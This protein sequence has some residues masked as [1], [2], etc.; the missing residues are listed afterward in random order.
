M[1]QKKLED[2]LINF[3]DPRDNKLRTEQEIKKDFLYF[4]VVK[5]I[6]LFETKKRIP[7]PF[8]SFFTVPKFEPKTENE[9][10][11]VIINSGLTKDL[12]CARQIFD[13]LQNESVTYAPYH[14]F[15]IGKIKNSSEE[16]RYEPKIYR[17]QPNLIG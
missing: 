8:L 6:N 5:L 12:D 17:S 9:I 4:G 10:L 14:E 2:I 16:I 15:W 13:Y 11:N 7:F 1:E 3:G